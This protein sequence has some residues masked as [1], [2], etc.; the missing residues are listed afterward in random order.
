VEGK[1]CNHFCLSILINLPW[2]TQYFILT[3][4]RVLW[5]IC[6]IIIIYSVY[7]IVPYRLPSLVLS[8]DV[9]QCKWAWFWSICLGDI[10]RQGTEIL[11]VG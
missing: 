4:N 10:G 6:I 8:P 9:A 2:S 3:T 7:Y 1:K 5:V 11:S